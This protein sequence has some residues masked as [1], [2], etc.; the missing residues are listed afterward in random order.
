METTEAWNK[1]DELKKHSELANSPGYE[2]EVLQ[3]AVDPV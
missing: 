2:T 1:L 3:E